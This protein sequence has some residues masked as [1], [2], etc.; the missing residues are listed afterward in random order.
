MTAFFGQSDVDE[1]HAIRFAI[2]RLPV[3]FQLSVGGEKVVVAEVGTELLA[4]RRHG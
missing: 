4:R 1:T 3:L 2:E